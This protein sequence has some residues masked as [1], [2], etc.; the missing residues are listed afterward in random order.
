MPWLEAVTNG[1]STTQKAPRPW[2]C[3]S[4]GYTVANAKN[5]FDI[6]AP[7]PQQ[8]CRLLDQASLCQTSPAHTPR[9][10]HDVDC[11]QDAT[12]R[13]PLQTTSCHAA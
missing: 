2:T 12:P 10:H 13:L 1:K 3:T 9:I 7:W 5:N 6:L 8:L 4:T 11:T